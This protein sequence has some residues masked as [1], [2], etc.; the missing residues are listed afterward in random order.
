MGASPE[1]SKP[2]IVIPLY[3]DFVRGG[4]IFLSGTS[5]YSVLIR[6]PIGE[7]PAATL[8]ERQTLPVLCRR[9]F[10]GGELYGPACWQLKF[11]AA[12]KRC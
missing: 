8:A 6:I 7:R 1:V 4:T 10:G 3:L 11:F 9:R 2:P 12:A 5:A